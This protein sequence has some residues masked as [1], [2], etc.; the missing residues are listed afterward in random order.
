MP[1]IKEIFI[2]KIAHSVPEERARRHKSL[3]RVHYSFEDEELSNR[4]STEVTSSIEWY[5]SIQL[6]SQT[7][8]YLEDFNEKQGRVYFGY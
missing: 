8:E 4:S 3:C 5:G 7:I 6:E 1:Y 2:E